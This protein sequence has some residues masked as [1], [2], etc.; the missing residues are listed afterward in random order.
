VNSRS[1][2][3]LAVLLLVCLAVA[4]VHFCC[5]SNAARSPRHQ[6]Q[7]CKSGGWAMPGPDATLDA[8][9]DCNPLHDELAPFLAHYQPV[10]ATCSRA[11]PQS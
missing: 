8:Q 5:E 2:C 11:P 7:L 3:A 6:C 1:I 9:L 10:E 4:Q